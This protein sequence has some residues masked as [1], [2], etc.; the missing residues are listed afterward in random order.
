MTNVLAVD[1]GGSALK[2][3]LFSIAGRRLAS[4]SAPIEFEEDAHGRSEQDPRL[5]WDL[6]SAAIE[7]IAGQT[8]S[9]LD[10]VGVIAI[11]GFTRTQVFVDQAGE[12]LRPAIGFRDRRGQALADA[13]LSDPNI[14]RH[15]SARQLNGFHPLARLL[16][17]KQSEPE[18]WARLQLVIEPKDYLNFR[19]TGHAKSDRIS[20]LWLSSAFGEREPGLARLAGI[21]RPVLPDLVAPADLV[22]HVRPGLPGAMSRLTGAMVLCGS[23]DTWSAVAGLGAMKAGRAYCISGSSEV[24]GLLVDRPVKAEGLNTV[25]WGEDLWQIGGPGQNGGNVLRWIVDLLDPSRRP[26]DQRLNDLLA[27][28]SGSAPL[29]FHPYLNGERTPFWDTDLRAGFIGLAASHAPGDLVRAVMEGTAFLNRIVLERAEKAAGQ[30]SGAIRIAGGGAGSAAWN[31]IRADILG[32]PVLAAP[33]QEMGLVGGLALARL[34]LKRDL[35]PGG[36]ERLG[37][38]FVRFGPDAARRAR[39]DALYRVFHASHSAIA[40]ASHQ[41]AAISRQF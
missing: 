15:P 24:L 3:S 23:N 14:A 38:D 37:A 17:L 29:L 2:V 13:A 40:D 34:A 36:G 7:D 9:G 8:G 18:A 22:G 6:L 10:A 28:R 4:V 31:Q 35:E 30:S 1:L 16:W 41:L 21:D 5:W 26:F 32:R 39:Y 12:V 20:Q 25:Q 27:A 19:L 11:C 33:G